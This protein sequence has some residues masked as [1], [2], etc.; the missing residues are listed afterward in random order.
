MHGK[1]SH[2]AARTKTNAKVKNIRESGAVI[3]IH[4]DDHGEHSLSLSLLLL[5]LLCK[6][7]QQLMG[8]IR[9]DERCVPTSSTRR[10]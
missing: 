4:H 2:K 10:R 1:G 6:R 5:L 8:L 7:Q 9:V 3:K